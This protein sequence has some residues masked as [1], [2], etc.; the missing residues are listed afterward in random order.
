MIREILALAVLAASASAALAQDG[1]AWRPWDD[2]TASSA[3]VQTAPAPLAPATVEPE[4]AFRPAPEV[5]VVQPPPEPAASEPAIETAPVVVDDRIAPSTPAASVEAQAIQPASDLAVATNIGAPAPGRGQVVFFRPSRFAG[6]ALS[7]SIRQDKTPFVKLGNG[8][9]AAFDVA[10]GPRAF[11]VQG[12]VEDVLHLE[13]DDGQTYYVRHSIGLGV[14][15]GR[16]N[17]A[18]A[19]AAA[20][21]GGGKMRLAKPTIQTA[22]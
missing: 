21:Q 13:I 16:P 20:F 18:P 8:S 7:F 22:D 11:S 4:P 5:D 2:A 3:A 19:D 10:P 14:L 17:L 1:G 6:A 12:E 9:Y 15:M